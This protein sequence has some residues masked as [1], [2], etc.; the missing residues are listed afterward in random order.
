MPDP[1]QHET[2]DT[3]GAGNTGGAENEA[4][5]KAANEAAGEADSKAA[6]KADNKYEHYEG[7]S[8]EAERQVFAEL[9]GRIVRVQEVNR[10]KGRLP[11]PDRAFH[12]KTT[13]AVDNARIRFRDDLPP[14]LTVGYARPGAEYRAVVRFSNA[15]GIP[16]PDAAPDLRGIAVRVVVSD[17][18]R[19]DLLLLNTPASHA[20]NAREFVGFSVVMAGATGTLSVAW[21]FL[22]KLPRAVGW[23]AANRMRRTLQRA[24]GRKV[25][26]LTRETYWSQGPVLWGNAGPVQYQL[27]PRARDASA[28][29]DQDPATAPAQAPAADRKDPDRLRTELARHLAAGDVVFE[30]CLQRFVDEH[31][32]PVEDAS[33]EWPKDQSPPV[34]VADVTLPAQD[35]T[36]EEAR[37]RAHRIDQ[38]VFTPWRTTE[39]FRPLGNLNRSRDAAYGASSSRRLGQE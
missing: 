34:P 3:G 36:T 6:N 26:S 37:A 22:V 15:S 8:A 11:G 38:L 27:R 2:G 13:L 19:H 17:Q 12:A 24:V 21:R 25:V 20:A 9:A 28:D 31:T 35:V 23:S 10:R 1:R 14:G 39:P 4:A 7:G 29:P 32:T 5:S 33:V 16:R 30:L 18:E